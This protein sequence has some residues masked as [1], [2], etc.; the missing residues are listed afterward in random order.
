M[1]AST[2]KPSLDRRPDSQLTDAEYMARRSYRMSLAREAA[3]NEEC[4]YCGVTGCRK[5]E[6]A[7]I[8]R[9]DTEAP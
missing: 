9:R 8:E 7:R 1:I 4:A 6:C 2:Y 5:P 3:E